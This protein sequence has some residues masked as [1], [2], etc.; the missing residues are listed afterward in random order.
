MNI[1]SA[2]LIAAAGLALGLTGCSLGEVEQGRVVAYDKDAKEVTVVHDSAMDPKSPKFDPKAKEPVY[3]T[4]PPVT[5]KLPTDPKEMGPEPKA[6]KRLKITAEAIVIDGKKIPPQIEIYDEPNKKLA[7]ITIEITD[8]QKDIGERHP[9]VY[10]SSAK[11]AKSFPVISGGT[12][13]V[14]SPRQRQLITFKVPEG[15]ADYPPETWA[16]GDEVRIYAKEKGQALR[17]MNIS[18]TNIFRR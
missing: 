12:I 17:F 15:Y 6:G 10:D 16:A 11:K 18:Q 9:M 8:L 3:D 2:L 1:K 5:F 13:Q 14:Y 4:L 7:Y